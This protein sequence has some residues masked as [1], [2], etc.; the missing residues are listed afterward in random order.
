MAAA[1]VT[2]KSWGYKV[3]G[4]TDATAVTTDK[5]RLRSIRLVGTAGAETASVADTKTDAFYSNVATT[6]NADYETPFYGVPVD[7]I[8]VTLSATT[9]TVYLLLA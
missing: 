6:A 8:R 1:T 3:T 2:K 7:G 5:V 9:A 4:G